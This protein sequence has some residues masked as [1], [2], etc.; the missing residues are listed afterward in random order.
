[1]PSASFQFNEAGLQA[2][3]NGPEIQDSMVRIAE[4]GKRVAEGLS[5]DFRET[6]EYADAFEVRP[7]TVV[8]KGKSRAA[9][10]LRN[11]SGH[12]AAVEFGYGGRAGAPGRTPHRVIGRTL[13]ALA[14]E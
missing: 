1:M 11:N 3:A 12:A 13:D 4:R 8:V 7:V 14:G 9:A 6:G 10:E 2:W 5:E